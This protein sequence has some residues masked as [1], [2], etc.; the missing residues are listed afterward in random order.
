[1]FDDIKMC[2]LDLIKSGAPKSKKSLKDIQSGYSADFMKKYND[3]NIIHFNEN[4]SMVNK[5]DN[6]RFSPSNYTNLFKTNPLL[7]GKRTKS[8]REWGVESASFEFSSDDRE[9]DRE[10]GDDEG[11]LTMTSCSRSYSEKYALLRSI[12][13]QGCGDE[14]DD[15][16]DEDDDDG[17][18]MNHYSLEECLAGGLVSQLDSFCTL[19]TSSFSFSNC[20]NCEK[21]GCGSK[22]SVV[23]SSHGGGNDD[24]GGEEEDDD[25]D[26][27]GGSTVREMR[28]TPPE[29]RSR[30]LIGGC[31]CLRRQ[32]HGEKLAVES[33]AGG[34]FG[35]N[36][37]RR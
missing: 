15:D 4:M 31:V 18:I 6:V 33:F 26:D 21:S 16:D 20:N 12:S 35:G 22:C 23:S 1:M 13:Q 8:F 24:D 19:C 14:L 5:L 32:Q 10:E 3:I 27:D 34:I 17:I 7:D 25:D 9:E 11:T 36:I 2:L 37:G 29:R 30:L 28:R